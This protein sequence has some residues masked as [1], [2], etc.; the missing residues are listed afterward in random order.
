MKKILSLLFILLGIT[1]YAQP[2]NDTCGTAIALTVGNG[3]CNSILY[4]LTGGTTTGNPATPACWS[5]NTMSTT[6]WFSFVATTADI[7]LSTNFSGTLA[8]TQIAVYS[9]SCGTLT[10]LACQED[11]N[12]AA[13]LLHTNII[14]HGLTIG[15]T[16]FIAV[17]GN[18]ASTGTFGICAQQAQPVGPIL[19]VQDCGTAQTLCSIGNVSV[20]DGPGGVGTSTEAPSCFGAPGERSS[21]WYTFTAATNGVLAFTITPNSVIDYD[22]A[23]YDTTT[24][25]PGTELSCNWSGVTGATG[26]TGLG[27]TGTQCNTTINLIAGHTYTILVDRFTSS[28]SSGFTLNFAGTTATFASPNPTFTATTACLGTATQFTNTTNGNFTYSWNFGDGTT[29][30]VE[31]PTHT[32]AAAG[33]YNVSLLLTA[34]P[35]GCQNQITLPVTVNPQPTVD[36]GNPSTICAGACV[37]LA[38]ST[39]AVGGANGPVTFTNNTVVAI[40]DSDTVTG[41]VSTIAVT[42]ITPNVV[43]ATSIVSVCL[44]I[45]HT[46]DSDLDIYLQAPNGTRIELSTDNG[47]L[48]NNYTNTCFSMSAT[49]LITAGTA[50]F[51][52]NFIPEQAFSLLNGSIING[53]WQLV[54]QDDAGGDVGTLNNWSITFQNTLPTFSWSPT[55]GMTNANTL[56][57]TVCP[58]TTTTYTLTANNGANCIVSDTVTITVNNSNT[59]TLTSAAATTSQTVCINTPI[60]NIIYTFGGGATGATVTGLPAGVTATVS[61]ST[62][63]ISGSPTTATGSPFNY[64][65]T[66]TGGCGVVSLSGTITVNAN[67]TLTLTSAIATTAQTICINTPITNIVYTLGNGATGATVTGLPAGVTATVS[68]STVMISGSPT[69]TT[70]SPFSYT[71][72]TTGGCGTQTLTGSITVNP[73]VT[74]SLTSAAATTTQTVCVNSAITNITYTFGSGATGATVTGLPAGVTA[75]VSGSTVTISGSPTTATGSPFSYTV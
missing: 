35:G 36:A 71:I 65:V 68:G 12:T 19:P 41:A 28:S 59:L 69:T 17:D 10:L 20:P 25:C 43:S 9:G 42:G 30:T 24:S 37:T 55:T 67:V 7:E 6:V 75:T 44:D 45:T 48:D 4:D 51:T 38:G 22:F 49:T 63:T 66:T 73:S 34:V 11:V 50:P 60:T 70:G 15:S 39:N 57:P 54:V 2:A 13:G 8:N 52:G 74:L 3:T 58:T 27:C 5:P 33:T 56:T 16:Y 18:G 32:Y 62:V 46:W 26:A 61:G 64:T 72:T 21:N 53:N 47:S 1:S 23:V 29:S 40:P 14:L 31:N